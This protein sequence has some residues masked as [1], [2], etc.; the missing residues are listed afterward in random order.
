MSSKTPSDDALE[1]LER[2]TLDYFLK[3]TN[4]ENGLVP[5]SNRK[6]ASSSITAVGLGLAAY[7]VAAERKFITRADAVQRVLTTLRYLW[8]SPQGQETDATGYKGFFYHFLDMR[9]GRRALKS[10]LST[11]DTTFLLA[12]HWPPP[13]TSTARRMKSGRYARSPTRS[14]AAST[15]GGRRTAI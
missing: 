3:E 9:T 2:D 12:G 8:D 4:A 11:I 5:D 1:K 15:G 7:V 10:E 13:P 6:G 14:I